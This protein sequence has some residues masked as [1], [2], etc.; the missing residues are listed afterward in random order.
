M[1]G[2]NVPTPY[3]P[4]SL[5]FVKSVSSNFMCVFLQEE[6][7][8]RWILELPSV[9]LKEVLGELRWLHPQSLEDLPDS[10]ADELMSRYSTQIVATL[11]D[12]RYHTPCTD[13]SL[14]KSSVS[15]ARARKD[16]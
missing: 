1:A 12:T 7:C 2:V 15:T 5:F 14:S 8:L 3:L 16:C 4:A 6:L 11:H 9:M 10:E 13:F